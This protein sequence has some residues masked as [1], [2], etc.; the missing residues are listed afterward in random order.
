MS[1]VF[2]VKVIPNAPK[3]K[4]SEYQPGV[5]K[6]S[7]TSPPSKGKA[8]EELVKLIARKLNLPKS[9]ISITSGFTSRLKTISIDTSLTYDELKAFLLS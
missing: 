4:I 2:K 3:V 1:L 8:N 9:K 6:V 7:L 5:L